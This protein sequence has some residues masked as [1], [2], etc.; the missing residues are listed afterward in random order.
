MKETIPLQGGMTKKVSPEVGFS[1]FD[2]P[3]LKRITAR[4]I[5]K[6]LK[7]SFKELVEM[8]NLKKFKQQTQNLNLIKM[9]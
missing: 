1:D 5:E 9:T 4:D 6:F 2:I 8:F 3:V 7:S